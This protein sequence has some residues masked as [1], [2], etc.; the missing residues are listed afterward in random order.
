MRNYDRFYRITEKLI[1]ANWDQPPSHT[2]LLPTPV[3]CGFVWASCENPTDGDFTASLVTSSTVTLLVNLF[4]T[5]KLN[6]PSR[7]L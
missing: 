6:L 1:G 7:V 3:S 2:R 5:S 4:L